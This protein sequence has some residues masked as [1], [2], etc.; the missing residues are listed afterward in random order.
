M[1]GDLRTSSVKVNVD[2]CYLRLLRSLFTKLAK[3]HISAQ[4]FVR[5]YAL[6]WYTYFETSQVLLFFFVSEKRGPKLE[7]MNDIDEVILKKFLNYLCFLEE[8]L[9][10]I[11]V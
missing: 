1:L 6:G 5:V 9:K 8:L 2:M 10:N 4:F 7:F 11:A 3:S